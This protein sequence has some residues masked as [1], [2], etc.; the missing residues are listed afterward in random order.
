[1]R[2]SR[3]FSS[4]FITLAALLVL[5]VNSLAA[6]PGIPI[7]P[8]PG[9]Q[10]APKTLSAA[11]D[12]KPGSVL[13]YNVY[14]SSSTSPAT[15]NTRISITNTAEKAI[16]IHLF[17]VDGNTC[18]PADSIVC[19]TARQT[20]SFRASDFDPGTM[21]YVVAVAIDENGCPII[22][23]A[24]IGDVFVKF[25]SGHQANLGAES[26]AALQAPNCD[27]T[28]STA[29][30][31]FDGRQYDQLPQTVAIDNLPSSVDGN[32]TM[33]IL[34]RVSGNLGIGTDSIGAIAGILYDDAEKASSF[35]FSDSKCQVKFIITNSLPRTA[36]RFTTIVPSGRSGWMK[37]YNYSGAP[38]LGAVI[39]FNSAAAASPTAFNQGHNLHKLRLAES[40]TFKIPV[41]PPNCG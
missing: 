28:M 30:L 22:H 14:T 12:Q 31:V 38:L 16:A 9:N 19:L 40:S 2:T 6:D 11:N 34:N 41:F 3:Y 23:N 24:L 10:T 39:N 26:I 37:L 4:F 8:I 27:N 32:Q 21:G 17:F 13:I 36:P 15:E 33:L 7:V 5:A 29:D 18:S 35:T 1:M 25:S 20:S